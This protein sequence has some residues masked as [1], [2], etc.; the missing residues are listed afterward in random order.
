VVTEDRGIYQVV[1]EEGQISAWLPGRLL[2]RANHG[3][4]LPKVGDWVGFHRVA[5]EEKAL[6]EQVLPRRTTLTRRVPGREVEEQVLV[7]NVDVALIVHALDRGVNPRLLERQLVMVRKGGIEPVI[8]LNKAD[9]AT[10]VAEQEQLARNTCGEAR[11]HFAS[12]LTRRGVKELRRLIKPGQTVVFLGISG[13]GKSSLVNSLMGEEVQHTIEVRKT[14][15][16][17]RHTT[18]AR[19]MFLL[20]G[21]GLIIDT[22]GMR[23]LQLWSSEENVTQAFEDIEALGVSCHFRD[24]THTREGRCSVLAAVEKGEISRER[25]ASF[26]KLRAEAAALKKEATQRYYVEQKRKTRVAQ[27][28]LF[29]KM[30]RSTSLE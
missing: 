24:C 3:S 13:V 23:E 2:H 5:G 27:N 8:V 26:Q 29:N 30:K 10:D 19:E 14:D 12:A 1:C 22:P 15:L 21:G 7:S 4:E 20:R 28:A 25:L 18:T 16:K 6:I 11:I 9:L 17:G